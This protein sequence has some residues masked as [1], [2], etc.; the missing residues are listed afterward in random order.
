MPDRIRN[1]QA[2]VIGEL[3]SNWTPWAQSLRTEGFEV[4]TVLQD[5]DEGASAFAVRV[6]RCLTELERSGEAVGRLVL[7]GGGRVGSDFLSARSL[8]I[9]ATAA[10]M[11]RTGGGEVLLEGHGRDRY[12]MQALATTVSGMVQGT[13]VR[14]EAASAPAQFA[15]V[16]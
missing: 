10:T 7:A 3:D 8:M 13:G 4:T 11:A 5:V 6:R 12:G 14:V 1:R 16:A 15:E 9:R 2:L